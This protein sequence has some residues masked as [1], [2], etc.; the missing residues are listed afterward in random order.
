[1]HSRSPFEMTQKEKH[2]ILQDAKN[3]KLNFIYQNGITLINLLESSINFFYF[4]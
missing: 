4:L 1:M 3:V 2:S